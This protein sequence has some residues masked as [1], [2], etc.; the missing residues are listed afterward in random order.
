MPRV[1]ES[2]TIN[3]LDIRAKFGGDY[4][5]TERTYRLGIDLRITRCIA[6]RFVGRVILET[7]TGGGFS[8]IALAQVAKHVVTIEIDSE[9]QAQARHNIAQA[10]LLDR[11]TLIA[12]DCLSEAV[13]SQVGHVD[14]AFLDPDWAVTGPEHVCRFRESNMRPPADVLLSRALALTRE[15]AMILPPSIDLQ[16]LA[17]LPAHELQSIYL[18][19]E[20]ALYCLYFGALAAVVGATELH[21]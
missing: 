12:G 17:A 15:V 2:A 4:W 10:Q 6:A 5:A 16:E 1:S 3:P 13:L 20:H 7:C 9:H 21:V 19:H 14:A 18:E 11:V 8:T